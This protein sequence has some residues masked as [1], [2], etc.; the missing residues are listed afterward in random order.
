MTADEKKPVSPELFKTL[1]DLEDEEE[2]RRAAMNNP[3]DA[4]GREEDRFGN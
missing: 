3:A 4:C 1:E 2:M